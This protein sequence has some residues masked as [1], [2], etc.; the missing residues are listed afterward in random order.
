MN[1]DFV[2]PAA[3]I[4]GHLLLTTTWFNLKEARQWLDEN[5]E[6]LFTRYL[7]KNPQYQPHMEFPIPRCMDRISVNSTTQQYAEKLMNS[8]PNYTQREQQRLVHKVP[9]QA[10]RQKSEIHI[11]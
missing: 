9:N 1:T 2:C 8:I 10:P 6:P 11:R 3:H 7:K 5:L 4:D